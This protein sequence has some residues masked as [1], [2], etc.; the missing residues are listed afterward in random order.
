M[1]AST[2]IFKVNIKVNLDTK[3]LVRQWR[4]LL[5]DD[6]TMLE[7]HDTLARYCD[8][9]VPMQEGVLAQTTEIT[10]KSVKY[11]QPYAH[12]QYM[13]ELYL[14]ANGSSWA[15]KDEKKYPSGLPL[16]HSKEKHLRASKEWDKAMMAERGQEFTHAIR[17]ILV[18]R[19]NELYG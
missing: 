10:A 2:D 16:V 12:Y 13:G 5:K 7:I 8:P 14:A 6:D 4:S 1:S 15:H 9:Y 17:D 3:R 11:T 19:A 18:R